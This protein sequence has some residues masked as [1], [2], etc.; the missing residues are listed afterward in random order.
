MNAVI[1]GDAERS[2]FWGGV[3]VVNFFAEQI[4]NY[5]FQYVAEVSF[6][7]TYRNMFEHINQRMATYHMARK[8]V[9][10]VELQ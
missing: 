2:F 7:H 5:L 9:S 3:L 8:T 10:E 1:R 4:K 6:G